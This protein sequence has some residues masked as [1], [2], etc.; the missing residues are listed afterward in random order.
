MQEAIS[1]QQAKPAKLMEDL[2]DLK[3]LH[4]G[5]ANFMQRRSCFAMYIGLATAF[6][7]YVFEV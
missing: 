5:D 7:G 2:Q 6:L 1:F 3:C 4:A